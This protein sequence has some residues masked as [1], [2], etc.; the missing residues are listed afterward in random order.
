MET[1]YF[2]GAPCHTYGTVPA[3][4]EK[5]PCFNLVNMALKEISCLDFRGKRVPQPRYSGVRRVGTS[6]QPGGCRA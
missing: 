3:V 6:L 5:A 1:I 4:G 2:K